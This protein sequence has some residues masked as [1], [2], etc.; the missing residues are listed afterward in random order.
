MLALLD[1][2]GLDRVLLVAHDWGAFVGYR[3]I[4]RE[5][6]RFDGYLVMNM[7]HPW[8]TPRFSAAAVC[9]GCTTRSPL[10]TVGVPLHDAAPSFVEKVILRI[11]SDMDP[12]ERRVFGDSFRNPVCAR[13]GRDTYRTFLLREIPSAR[14]ESRDAA[15]HGADS[16]AVR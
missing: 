14:K 7:A 5:P 3:M 13:A 6:E 8:Q 15:R 12:E 2:L 4:L 11:G 16:R 10:A 1:A 9:G